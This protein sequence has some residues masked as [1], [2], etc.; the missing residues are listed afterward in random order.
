MR[1]P[2]GREWTRTL[3]AVEIDDL[4]PDSIVR[5]TVPRGSGVFFTGLTI[6]GSFA[7]RSGDRRRAAFPTHYVREGTWI[8]RVDIQEVVDASR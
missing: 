5:L 2:D 3:F 6:H 8:Y 4:D 1:D 7:N